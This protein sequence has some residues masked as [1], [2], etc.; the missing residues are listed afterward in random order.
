MSKKIEHTKLRTLNDVC[1]EQ[2]RISKRIS[3]I[4]QE[5]IWNCE[6]FFYEISSL[7]YWIGVISDKLP[8]LSPIIQAA[9]ALISLLFG[10]RRRR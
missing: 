1:R 10:R 9:Y 2:R 6:D 7:D 5:L 4:E 8:G 3:C